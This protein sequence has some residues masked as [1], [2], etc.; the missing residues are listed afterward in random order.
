MEAEHE[1][2]VRLAEARVNAALKALRLIGNLSN[3]S[4][5]AYREE[6]VGKIFNVL[7]QALTM[8]QQRFETSIKMEAKPFSLHGKGKS[9]TPTSSVPTAGETMAPDQVALI[10]NAVEAQRVKDQHQES[11]ISATKKEK[12]Y[13]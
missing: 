5:Y 8:A 9:T 6:E 7:R 1:K 11:V 13:V 4:N 10:A 2:F 12:E 3:R